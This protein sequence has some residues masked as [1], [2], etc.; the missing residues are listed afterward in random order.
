[1]KWPV[2]WTLI[3]SVVSF[4]LGLTPVGSELLW[5]VLKPLG[6]GL[7]IVYFIAQLLEKET[8]QYDED[9]RKHLEPSRRSPERRSS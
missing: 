5:G 3:A 6:A 2:K 1:M 7:F 9:H 8:A 4:G